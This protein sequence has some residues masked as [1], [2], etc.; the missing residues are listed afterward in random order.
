MPLKKSVQSRPN[1]RLRKAREQKGWTQQEVADLIGAPYPFM[2]NRWENGVVFPSSIYREKL[3]DLFGQPAEELG[4]LPVQRVLLSGE[5]YDSTIPL[6]FANNQELVGRDDLLTFLRQR[7]CTAEGLTQLA[8]YGLP[9]VGKTTLIA[10]LIN[11]Q[12]IQ[13]QFNDGILWAG[14]GLHPNLLALFN[15]WGILLGIGNAEQATLRDRESWLGWLHRAIG[16]RRMLIVID[17][18]WTIEHAYSC[19]AGGPNCVYLLTTRIPD[20]ALNFAGAQAIQLR[21]LDLEQGMQLLM[22]LIPTIVEIEIARLQQLVQTVGGLPLALTLFGHHLLLQHQKGSRRL[23]ATLTHLRKAEE[24]IQLQQPQAGLLRDF[25]LPGGSALSLQAII[26]L[27]MTGLERDAREMLFALSVFPA[28]PGTFTEEAA[29]AVACRP[30]Q[31]LDNLVDAGLIECTGP[32]RYTLHQT[33]A[34]YARTQCRDQLAEQ[35]MARYYVDLL[36]QHGSDYELLEQET[37][38]LIQG[39]QYAVEHNMHEI[40]IQGMLA[41]APFLQS[42]A[43][44]EIAEKYLE[45][46]KQCAGICNNDGALASLLHLSGRLAFVQGKYSEAEV[47]YQD[48]LRLARHTGKTE[49][50]CQLLFRSGGLSSRRG[51]YVQAEKYYREGLHLAR[52]QNNHESIGEILFGLSSLAYERGEYVEA[53]AL[54]REGLIIAR[55][56]ASAELTCKLLINLGVMEADRAEYILAEQNWQ[57]ALTLAR[58]LRLSDLISH[59]LL[60]LGSLATELRDFTLADRYFQECLALL[61]QREN[62]ERM[63]HCL[64]EF[65]K[66]FG[67]QKEYAQAQTYLREGVAL[68]RQVGHRKLLSE[69]LLELAKLLLQKEEIE[70]AEQTFHETLQCAPQGQHDTTI[71]AQYGLA[72]I[73][74]LRGEKDKAYRQAEQCLAHFEATGHFRSAEIRAWLQHVRSN[75]SR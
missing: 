60:N 74:A 31:L 14:V 30:L 68:A 7:L 26:G 70:A 45:Q 48:A 23:Q 56:I 6:P 52:Q 54:S 18:A 37:A 58:Q 53:S 64:L 72:Q 51:E 35:C 5:F 28:K 44:Y 8:F 34:D 39:L 12:I 32:V 38:N 9:G 41:F 24:R 27:S 73:A 71:E 20:V 36:A 17:D 43:M 13:E 57:E 66:M 46:A 75:T 3:A 22:Q 50:I 63:S 62:H 47:A 59:L 21:E 40:F 33:I 49:E 2:V 15:R 11:E 67:K 1:L 69:M 10:Q 65:G 42:R 55:R 19:L 61:K 25:R 4:L 29:L 16:T